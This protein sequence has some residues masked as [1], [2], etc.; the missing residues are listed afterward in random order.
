MGPAMS[1]DRLI[2]TLN[3]LGTLPATLARDGDFC[4]PGVVYVAP[5]D[6]HLLVDGE[7][8]LVG[9]G[10]F[11]NLSR[12]AIDPL[13]RSVAV[14]A[15]NLA[16]GVLLS[17]FLDDGVVGL[18]TIHRCGGIT[19]VQDPL[20]AE[21]HGMPSSAIARAHV[22][23]TLPSADLAAFIARVVREAPPKAAV[24][25]DELI[26]EVQLAA[27]VAADRDALAQLVGPT[28]EFPC[29]DCGGVLREVKGSDNLRFRCRVGHSLTA[30][31]LS[32]RQAHQIEETL[33]VSLR[34]LEE[35]KALLER[36]ART[37][38]GS[39]TAARAADIQ[40]HIDRLRGLL[41]SE[42]W[43][44][45]PAPDESATEHPEPAES[46]SRHREHRRRARGE[47]PRR[48]PESARSSRRRSLGA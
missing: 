5:P 36:I 16:V 14:S 37:P 30:Q 44:N 7:R 45:A 31:I 41:L 33:W 15:G 32:N 17:G 9:R 2:D 6:H 21:Q 20:D 29:P 27:R 34:M 25:P 42:S 26:R 4:A 48:G 19:L 18:Q 1:G 23:H 13:F 46:R 47:S 43:R 28:T 10:P 22:D 24:I 8:L 35:R 40:R 38:G 39:G 12:P 11:E 3:R